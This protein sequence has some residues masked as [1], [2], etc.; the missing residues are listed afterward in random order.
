MHTLHSCRVLDR[1]HCTVFGPLI[2]KVR[3]CCL[4]MHVLLGWFHQSM[5]KQI[6]GSIL[7]KNASIV[8]CWKTTQQEQHPE[9]FLWIYFHTN[10]A[11]D[12]PFPV[13]CGDIYNCIPSKQWQTHTGMISREN[14]TFSDF[15]NKSANWAKWWKSMYFEPI[16]FHHESHNIDTCH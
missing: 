6:F 8:V 1:P 7:T 4:Q 10:I 14:N 5:W 11:V 12:L 3:L 15:G 16:D 13:I 9:V 2:R